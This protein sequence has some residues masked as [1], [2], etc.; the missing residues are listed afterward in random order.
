MAL[1]EIDQHARLYDGDIVRLH[2]T[3][4]GFTYITAAQVAAIEK[5]VAGDPRFHILRHSIPKK[6]G[7][8]KLTDFTIDCEVDTPGVTMSWFTSAAV[9]T[10]AVT[11]AVIAKVIM[12]AITVAVVMLTLVLVEK[13]VEETGEAAAKSEGAIKALPPAIVTAI[14]AYIVYKVLQ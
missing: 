2:F 4:T 5:K 10:G 13:V 14:G 3:V 8:F 12:G 9:A 7:L 11:A 1:V 6:E